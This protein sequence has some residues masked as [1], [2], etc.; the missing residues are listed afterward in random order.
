MKTITKAILI[1]CFSLSQVLG[2]AGAA[3]IPYLLRLVQ[4]SATRHQQLKMLIEQSKGQENLLKTINSGIDN[5]IGIIELAPIKSDGV[6]ENL[7]TARER[8][9]MIEQVY[10]SIPQSPDSAMLTLHDQSVAE[11]LKIV[12]DLKNYASEQEENALAIAKQVIEAS[13][14]GAQRMATVANSQIL[15]ALSQIIRINGQI[16][17]LQSEFLAVGNK[18]HKNSAE[19]FN[20]LRKEFGK[21]PKAYFE[22]GTLPTF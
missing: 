6:L 8:G 22:V 17:K 3:Q 12:N 1:F 9:Q 11:S 2:F 19:H 5:A 14:K 20:L 7:K 18:I 10:G 16:L 13:P 15:H 4:E 21:I